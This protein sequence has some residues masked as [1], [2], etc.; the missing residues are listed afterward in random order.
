MYRTNILD[1]NV[2]LHRI[3]FL[4]RNVSYFLFFRSSLKFIRCFSTTVTQ[5]DALDR[6][7]KNSE[8]PFAAFQRRL[9]LP[10]QQIV[11][12]MNVLRVISSRKTFSTVFKLVALKPLFVPLEFRDCRVKYSLDS[13]ES[14]VVVFLRVLRFPLMLSNQVV[15]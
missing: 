3:I 9:L 6:N 4:C 12:F 14:S 13:P 15:Q 7:P 10:G 5:Q 11:T 2:K 1:S 8:N